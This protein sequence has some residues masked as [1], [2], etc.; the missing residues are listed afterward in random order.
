MLSSRP[1]THRHNAQAGTMPSN[2]ITSMYTTARREGVV[3][4]LYWGFLPHCFEA[5]PHDVSVSRHF[6]SAC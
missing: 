6:T 5:M 1:L 2:F 3:R 4:G